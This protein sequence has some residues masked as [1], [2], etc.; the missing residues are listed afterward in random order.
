MFV[1]ALVAVVDSAGRPE[2]LQDALTSQLEG[3]RADTQQAGDVV[4]MRVLDEHRDD[5]PIAIL[6]L[7]E[8]RVDPF[9]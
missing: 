5:R 1:L 4:R 9:G 8:Q 3:V 7:I 6:Y 2:P